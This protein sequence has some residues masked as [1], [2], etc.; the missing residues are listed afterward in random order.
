M[1]P[2]ARRDRSASI[3]GQH[4]GALKSRQ[5]AHAFSN[6]DRSP[7][8]MDREV[9]EIS[10]LVVFR[11]WLVNGGLFCWESN[12]A[13]ARAYGPFRGPFLHGGRGSVFRA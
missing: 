9:P 10:A 2:P 3:D 5:Q 13:S 12:R 6:P 11:D 1:T 4:N 7:L 8:R